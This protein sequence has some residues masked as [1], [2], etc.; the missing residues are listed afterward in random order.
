MELV[1]CLCVGAAHLFLAN[2]ENEKEKEKK[3]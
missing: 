3:W 2:K 1:P